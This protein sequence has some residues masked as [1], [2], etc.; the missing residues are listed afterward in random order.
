MNNHTPALVLPHGHDMAKTLENEQEERKS[1]H[2][3]ISRIN[4]FS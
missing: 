1:C 4:A 2:A 3:N